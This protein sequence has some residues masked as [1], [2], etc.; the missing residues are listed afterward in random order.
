MTSPKMRLSRRRLLHAASAVT[1]GAALSKP[2]L[3]AA[4]SVAGWRV[5]V[6]PAVISRQ[7]T[8]TTWDDTWRRAGEPYAGTT[9]RVPA[10]VTGHWG[11][12][13]EASKGFAE[14]TGIKSEWEDV[15]YEQQYQKIFLDLTAKSG[16]YDLIPLNYAWFG[17][18]MSG[19]HLEPVAKYLADE[20]FPKVD[21]SI[22]I[23]R[24][25]EV[26]TL[27]EGKQY[28]LPWLG[29]AM[30]FPYNKEHFTA[31]GLDPAAPPK[32]W[33]E[34]IETGKKLTSGDR[35]GFSLMGGRQIQVMCT[36]A[37][38]L[39]SFNKDFYD[40]SG[41]PQF[42]T[43]EGIKAMQMMVSL[44]PISPPGA[45]TWDIV[46]ASEAVAQ[47]ICSTEIQWPGILA[48]LNDPKAP[49]AGKMGFAPP[50]GRGPLGGWGN[51]ISAYSKHKE[52]TWLLI[53]YLTTTR[54]Q[55]EF[56]PKGYA[57]TAQA[58]FKDPDIQKIYPYAQAAGQAM[59]N[60]VPWPRTQESNDVFTIM[61]KHIN[62]VVVGQ[63]KAEDAARAMDAEVLKL[64]QERG[65]ITS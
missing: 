18:F 56:A 19:N 57:I 31:A 28:G 42:A 52:A 1:A 12:N 55:K 8:D 26:Y 54:I 64:R 49:V 7:A 33:D 53:N 61:V 39:F 24:L 21:M 29:D 40:A 30:I 14:L 59:A 23:P 6:A 36:Y 34:V 16:T 4:T 13:A 20:R 9:L 35:Y 37:A 50:P 62:A 65:M 2:Q 27:W 17:G 41:R 22:F 10:G 38:I 11:A 58:L 32:T 3:G 5:G 47:G 60:G 43:P 46:A 44:V 15:A 45:K 25:V 51:A 48:S 63:E